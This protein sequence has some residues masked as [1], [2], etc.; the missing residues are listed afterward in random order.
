MKQRKVEIVESKEPYAFLNDALRKVKIEEAVIN[1]YAEDDKDVVRYIISVDG[2]EH[3]EFVKSEDLYD[4]VEDFRINKKARR[5][6]WQAVCL[7]GSIGIET[8]ATPTEFTTYTWVMD[9][10]EPKRIEVHIASLRYKCYIF[11]AT[12]FD[13]V[14]NTTYHKW[15]RSREE[16]LR[17]NEYKVVDENGERTVKGEY[18]K[19]QLTD[20]QKEAFNNLQAA[21]KAAEAAGIAFTWDNVDDTIHAFNTNEMDDYFSTDEYDEGRFHLG[22]EELDALPLLNFNS[23]FVNDD[24]CGVSIKFKD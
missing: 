11:T 4:T 9:N 3:D 22:Y 2:K 20:K 6:T 14:T 13:A 15:Y 24:C 23:Q 8:L 17:W 10:G 21:F 7:L 12:V 19:L 18:L 5:D 1:L 16:C